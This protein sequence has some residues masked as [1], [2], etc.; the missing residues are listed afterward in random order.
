MTVT[1]IRHGESLGNVARERAEAAGSEV[2]DVGLR[3]ADVEL[4]AAGEAQAAAVGRWLRDGPADPGTIWS[5]PYR[6]AL[7]TAQIAA[8]PWPARRI[9]VDERLRDRELGILDGLTRAGVD[10]R[11]PTEAQRRAW[12]GKFYYRPPGGESWADVA[13]RLRAKLAELDGDRCGAN[14]TVFAHD[15]IV[16]LAR[17]VLEEM[18][19]EEI[20]WLASSTSILNGAVTRLRRADPAAPWVVELF[21]VADHL[22]AEGAPVT[23]HPAE[24]DALP[25]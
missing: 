11:Y 3:D 25:R 4:S 20:L 1:L 15:A 16:L 9:A 18:D 5:S 22:V 6:R 14:V 2:I 21:N 12:L 7:R 24:R 17:Y 8:E 23:E 10:A 19:E 13:L